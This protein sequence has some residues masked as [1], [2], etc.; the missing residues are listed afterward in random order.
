MPADPSDIALMAQTMWG[1]NNSGTPQEYAAIANVMRNRMMSGDAGFG[2]NTMSRVL[3]A[4]NKPG[5]KF[6]QFSPWNDPKADNFPTKADPRDPA[7]QSAY[8]IA[9]DVMTG[10]SKDNTNGA[11]YY[12]NPKGMAPGAATPSFA[13]GRKGLKIGAHTFYGPMQRAADDVD[14]PDAFVK[15]HIQQGQKPT[16]SSQPPVPTADADTVENPDAF[17]KEHISG[18]GS[19]AQVA[20]QDGTATGDQSNQRVQ[21][22]FA[23]MAKQP[24]MVERMFPIK[25][26][27]DFPGMAKRYGY[28]IA[29]EPGKTGA[30]TA[31]GIAG[32]AALPF[33]GP[34]AAPVLGL[35]SRAAPWV[36]M[37][38]LFNHFQGVRSL[39][40]LI[41]RSV[42]P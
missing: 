21:Q 7:Y 19:P 39:Y 40:D 15:E 25:S 38:E 23:E 10:N 6:H 18:K 3:L 16:A 29:T 30:L 35:A 28:H 14:D 27:T 31:A 33:A 8:R 32:A 34:V 41:H 26:L 37:E 12:Y 22:G 4:P 2:G 17:V 1:E 36:G 5:S 20:S 24:D 13:A 42:T 9:S 11:V